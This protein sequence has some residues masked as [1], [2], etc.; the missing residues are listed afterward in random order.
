MKIAAVCTA[1]HEADILPWTT[2]HLLSQG[3]DS[4]WIEMSVGDRKT[5]ESIE[6]FWHGRNIFVWTQTEDFHDQ[7]K[8]IDELTRKA[9]ADWIIPFDADEFIY[10]PDPMDT[11]RDVIESLP[12]ECSSISMPSFKHRDWWNRE[13]GPPSMSK[14]A[15]RYSPE[16]MVGPGNHTLTGF[17][18]DSIRVDNALMIREIQYRSFDHFRRKVEERSRTIDPS[19]G[20]E[21]G[22]HIR[23]HNGKSVVELHEAWTEMMSIPTVWDPIPSSIAPPDH[24][25]PPVDLMPMVDLLEMVKTE[26][27]DIRGHLQRLYDIVGETGTDR[28]IECGVCTGMSTVAFLATGVQVESCDIG[29]VRVRPEVTAA[30]NWSLRIGS[31]LEWS[32]DPCLIVFIDTTHEYRQSLDELE[33]FWPLVLPGGAMIWHDT[34]SYPQQARAIRHWTHTVDDI[35]KTEHYEFD[36]GLGVFWKAAK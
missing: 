24:L 30:S 2:E 29:N 36:N 12:P 5:L 31:D 10:A 25:A 18:P 20:P 9:N 32:P 7:P 17:P 4:V 22:F 14:V 6:K 21:M 15:Y 35:A 33:K 34:V 8:W 23:Q 13:C 11:I 16:V 27:C 3:I 1:Y 26:P 28:V 19:F